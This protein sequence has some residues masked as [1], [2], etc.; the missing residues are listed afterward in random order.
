[1]Q[2]LQ[3]G[4]RKAT[5]GEDC[6]K[7]GQRFVLQ[8]Q[9]SAPGGDDHCRLG[10]G[11]GRN[12]VRD[13]AWG[14]DDEAK[15]CHR[16]IRVDV[17]VSFVTVVACFSE[18]PLTAC[19]ASAAILRTSSIWLKDVTSVDSIKCNQPGSVEDS[20]TGSE[21]SPLIFRHIC[22]SLVLLGEQPDPGLN[23]L[24]RYFPATITN[25][26][27]LCPV[28]CTTTEFLF[29]AQK[30]W[31]RRCGVQGEHDK[32]GGAAVRAQGYLS[33]NGSRWKLWRSYPDG[34]D[35]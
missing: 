14:D 20:A 35:R 13:P 2:C 10:S 21:P 11:G 12:G 4:I 7:D 22:Y 16:G 18:N 6:S 24:F 26:D 32:R 19:T 23:A 9:G 34:G 31:S 30:L 17:Y 29:A 27:L 28:C 5:V 15:V 1:M 3:R 8:Q 33:C 25:F